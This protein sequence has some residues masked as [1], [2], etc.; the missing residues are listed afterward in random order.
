[1]LRLSLPIMLGNMG[2]DHLQVQEGNLSGNW[3]L[4]VPKVFVVEP[5]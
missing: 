4:G 1:M 2:G 5:P 3:R